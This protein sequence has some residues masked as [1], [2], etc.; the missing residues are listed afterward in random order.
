[1][2]GL[3]YDTGLAERDPDLAPTIVPEP[4]PAQSPLDCAEG[5]RFLASGRRAD[6][7]AAYTRAVLNDSSSAAA[8]DGL[9]AALRAGR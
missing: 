3:R 8:Y 1:M 7:I 9:A 6:A 2:R 4:D 5:R